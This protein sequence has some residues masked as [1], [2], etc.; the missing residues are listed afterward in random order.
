MQR[1]DKEDKEGKEG[2]EGPTG[3]ITHKTKTRW[4]AINA[5]A[6]TVTAGPPPGNQNLNP[7][8]AV[9]KGPKTP[10]YCWVCGKPDHRAATCPGKKWLSQANEILVKIEKNAPPAKLI[11]KLYTIKTYFREPILR[12]W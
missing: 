4:N 9:P 10:Q 2:K 8:G 12:K 1:K 6:L 7:P 3:P 5:K 11:H